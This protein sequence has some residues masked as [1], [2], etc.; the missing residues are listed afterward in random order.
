MTVP[1]MQRLLGLGHT[2][3]YWLVQQRVFDSICNELTGR[4]VRI[5]IASFEEW[6]A[7]QFHYHKVIGEAPG[8]NWTGITLSA[9]EAAELLGVNSSTIYD[10]LKKNNIRTAI[11]SGQTRIYIDS[12][13]EW[14][15]TQQHYRKV[16]DDNHPDW[17]LMDNT[18]STKEAAD[19]LG[20]SRKRLYYHLR[21]AGVKTV[22]VEGRI[23]IC[24]DS[25]EEYLK[26]SIE[27]P[28]R[29]T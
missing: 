21:K 14:Y 23:R 7:N 12:F 4:K 29:R 18:I 24:K 2:D 8:A 15:V 25:F 20:I 9:A 10:I 22:Q 11:V 6:Y 26:G 1:E 5:M 27:K 28:K 13:D 17:S 16:R 19:M 3:A